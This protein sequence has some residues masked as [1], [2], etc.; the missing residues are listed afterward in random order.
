MSDPWIAEAQDKEWLPEA[1]WLERHATILADRD[2]KDRV[3]VLFFGDSI[4][5]DW[6]GTGITEWGAHLAPLHS[7]NAGIGGDETQHLLWRMEQGLLDG[8]S[9]KACS[10]LIG[11]NNIG[12]AGANAADTVKGIEAVVTELQS[13]LP[14][15][16]ILL[17]L[18]LP[19]S[20][21]PDGAFRQTVDQA[22][23]LIQSQFSGREGI[24]LLDST[25]PFLTEE[26]TIPADLMPDFLHLS[27]EGY[28]LW[29]ER[30][31]PELKSLMQA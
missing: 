26:K 21:H 10:L 16:Q 2:S 23:Q 18:I 27:P 17:H 13:R 30:L 7:L 25:D 15:M 31:L 4:T 11:T 22:N 14:S 9:P 28:R 1:E 24:T 12:N 5:N 19:R 29:C 6:C 8:L 20:E 3:E